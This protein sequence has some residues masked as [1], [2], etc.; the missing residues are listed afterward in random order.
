MVLRNFYCWLAL[1]LGGLSAGM[2][3]RCR[4]DEW[5]QWRGPQRD[6]VWREDGLIQKFA[7]AQIALR[8][9]APVA[10]GYSGP[11]VA[12][13]RVYVT[14]RLVEPKQV[15][16]VHCFD[17]ESGGKL[18]TH[19]YDCR[20]EK[21]S[22]QDGPRAAVSI[23]EGRAFAL[24]TMGHLHCLDAATGDVLWARDLNRE[25]R[26]VMPIW[27][28]AASPL[29]DGDRVIVQ[30]GG[31]DGACIVAFDTQSGEEIW[32]ALDDRASYAA[33]II[34]EEGGQ[35]VLVCWTGDHVAGLVPETGRVLWK[36]PFQPTRM[37]IGIATPVYDRQRLFVTSFYDGS[38]MLR[39]G[40]KARSAEPMWRRLG[41]DEKQTDGLH[42]II[43]TPLIQGEHVYGVDSYG[44]LRCL[45][46]ASGDRIWEDRTAVDRNRWANIHM[47]RNGE[48]IWMFNEQGEL[49]ISR[50]SESGFQEISRAQLIAPTPG[51]LAR[52][53]G[54]CWSHPAYAY[55]HVFARNDKHLVCASLAAE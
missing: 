26:I 14:D 37:V 16:R 24:G 20:Y 3:S 35:R 22:Y 19:S 52:R 49:I 55:R 28:I 12:E 2:A 47:V 8:W 6:G 40:M 13:G 15:E 18:W 45:D 32:K 48:R 41:P 33:P 46:A 44:E 38:L 42:S 5:P 17:W 54:V 21:V 4:A 25:Y 11:T 29:V 30:I 1:I 36:H 7:G 31:S 50:L 51:Q 53:E 27:G 39:L 9:K 43:S 23:D 34:V 10:N